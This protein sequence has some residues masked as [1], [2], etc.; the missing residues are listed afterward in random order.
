M[1]DP[2]LP[3][4][5]LLRLLRPSLAALPARPVAQ[6]PVLRRLE[7]IR[8]VV[9]DFYDTL[10]LAEWRAVPAGLASAAIL[11]PL[12]MAGLARQGGR[13]PAL[14]RATGAALASAIGAAHARRHA[15][16]PALVQP[17]IDIRDIWREA[18]GLAATDPA[19][20][21]EAAV[22][23]EAWTSR[24]RAAGAAAATLARLRASGLLLGIASNAQFTAPALFQLHFG[25][26]PAAAGFSPPLTL[27]SHRLGVAK[28]DPR[29][30]DAL[31][32][33]AASLGL[34]PAA[35]LMVGNDPR[36]DIEPAARAGFRT[37]LFAG[38]QR[39]LRPAARHPSDATVTG[40][41]QLPDLLG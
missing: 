26:T 35:V 37:C 3:P 14:A 24:T 2:V 38:D 19:K 8:A 11:P 16:D 31:A 25:T 5:E 18:F 23:W 30:F 10:V 40:F 28:P 9:F 33:G 1:T 15:A 27:W 17:E 36:R 13:I 41:G 39:C 4:S 21:E 34:P 20:T 29:F 22:R 6:P 7:G 12:L 32:A